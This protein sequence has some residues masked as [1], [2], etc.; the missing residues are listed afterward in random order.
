[1]DDITTKALAEFVEKAGLLRRELEH[2]G[3]AAKYEARLSRMAQ[4]LER[5]ATHLAATDQAA[6]DAVRTAWERPA[7]SLAFRNAT[8]RKP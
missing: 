6:A 5:L 3:D 1:M 2:A 4:K 7:R 8:H